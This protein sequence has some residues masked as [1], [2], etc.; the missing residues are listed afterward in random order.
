MTVSV[1]CSAV[2]FLSGPFLYVDADD[3]VYFVDGH[4]VLRSATAVE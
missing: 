1:R 4:R 3:H 2:L